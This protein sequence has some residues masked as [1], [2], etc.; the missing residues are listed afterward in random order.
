MSLAQGQ[1]GRPL[2]RVRQ[3]ARDA[4]A[5]VAFSAAASVLLAV[6]LTLVLSLA[7]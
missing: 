7:G 3:E 4:L 5:V 6:T 1:H 2:R